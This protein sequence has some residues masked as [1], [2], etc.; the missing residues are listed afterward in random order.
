MK[1]VKIIVGI[2]IFL[3]PFSANAASVYV[4]DEI[5]QGK[6]LEIKI[7]KDDIESVNASFNGKIVKFYEVVD[8]PN[9]DETIN[10]GEFLK[11]MFDN[12]DFG[13]VDTFQ[14]TQFPDVPA[15]NPFYQYVSK[16]SALDIIHGYEDGK[17]RPYTP[18]TRGQIA[19]ILVRAFDPLE[20]LEDVPSFEDVPEDHR[21]YE[22]INQTMKAEIFKGYPDGFMRP[23]RNINFDE[24]QIVITRAAELEEFTQIGEKDYLR[25]FVGLHRTKDAGAK[26]LS[27]TLNKD[28][29]EQVEVTI[30]VG[31]QNYTV[32][33]FTLPET[34]TELFGQTQQDNTWTMI[35]AAKSNPREEQLW[36]GE[37]IVPTEGV[38]TLGFGDKLY[39]NGAYSG[40]HFGLDY[41]NVEGTEIYAS[42]SGIV[43]LA[44]E[45][46]SYG[47][48]IIIDHGH[49]VFTMYLHMS[50]LKVEEGQVVNKGDLIGLMGST[51]I[52][53]GSHLHFTHFI[54]DVIVDSA[55]WYAAEM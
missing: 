51:G 12:E 19:K 35:N 25:A 14:A 34:K 50:A 18:I 15:G 37:F 49:N 32:V 52:A 46:M 9:W 4:E 2:G 45:T 44:D 13:D 6:T 31:E 26:T 39:I 36:E 53:T 43:T 38:I 11:L 28:E 7:A 21:F 29:S 16:A 33:S 22:Y 54:G 30:D 24:A 17:F 55:E 20:K 47:N 41:G 48:T 10:R 5:L 3:I 23:D 40:S 27:L 1:I 42:N 8:A